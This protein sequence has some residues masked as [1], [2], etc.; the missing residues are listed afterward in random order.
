MRRGSDSRSA[1]VKNA[2][3]PFS[4]RT[5]I[6]VNIGCLFLVSIIKTRVDCMSKR[7]KPRNKKGRSKEGQ[8][9][10]SQKDKEVPP[11]ASAAP[12]L[13]T[14]VNSPIG[15]SEERN[16]PTKIEIWKFRLEVT[17]A[18]I[19]VCLAVIYFC[20]MWA[21]L[22]QARAAEDQLKE[23]HSEA[24]RAE[25]AWVY[26]EVKDNM[27]MQESTNFVLHAKII[28]SGK[29]IGILTGTISAVSTDESKIPTHDPIA[30]GQ[31]VILNPRTDESI[32]QEFVISVPIAAFQNSR[33]VYFCGT[34]FYR[35]IF[36][37]SHWTEF[38]YHFSEGGRFGTVT[39]FHNSSDD[40]ERQS[41]K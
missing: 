7:N 30:G 13:T 37:D 5:Q 38:C 1:I 31:S 34:V 40:A 15:T 33:G 22:R 29:T 3:L 36:G 10:T 24:V 8:S 19:G 28:N 2:G 6:E 32:F 20:Q 26:V 4:L 23:M 41:N 27:L 9:R 21:N 18:I 11:A 14:G 17:A 25:R 39:R 35:D 16:K 12:N